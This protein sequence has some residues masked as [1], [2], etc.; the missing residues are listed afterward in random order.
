ML[1][2]IVDCQRVIFVI[3][4]KLIS[5]LER[6]RHVRGM[7]RARKSVILKQIQMQQVVL[8]N[9]MFYSYSYCLLA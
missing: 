6:I 3:Q 5:E 8:L 9:I 2:T 4:P 1:V 7:E